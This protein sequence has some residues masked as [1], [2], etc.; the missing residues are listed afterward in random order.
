MENK[1]S[2]KH[3]I[4]NNDWK[5]YVNTGELGIHVLQDIVK[6]IKAGEKLSTKDLA[7]YTSHGDILETLLRTKH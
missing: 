3:L 2:I 6:R 4:S 7:I 1:Y 5:K